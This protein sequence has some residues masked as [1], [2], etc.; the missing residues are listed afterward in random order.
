MEVGSRPIRVQSIAQNGVA[1]QVP[2]EYIQPPETR[3]NYPTARPANNNPIPSIDLSGAAR[4]ADSLRAEIGAACRDWGAFHV[5]NH[6]VPPKLLDE[7]RRVGR[8]FFEACPMDEKLRYSC[9]T[10]GAA[11][12][13]YGSRML[14]ASNDTVLDWRDYFDHHTLPVS[15]R[16]PS[17]WPQFPPDYRQRENLE[18][19]IQESAPVSTQALVP[20]ASLASP[21]LQLTN[22]EVVVE[23]SDHMKGLAQKLLGLIS[24]SLGL[25]SSCIE[26][27][28][29][30]FYQNISIN[31]YPPCPQP[32]LTLG[33]QAHS[34]MGAITLLIQDDV[35][36]LQIF[37]DDEW[38]TV[39]PLSDAIRK[40]VT[41]IQLTPINPSNPSLANH[42]SSD[43][44]D[45]ELAPGYPVGKKDKRHM[46]SKTAAG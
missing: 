34:D 18:I 16:D 14:V 22:R 10:S 33:L 17:R 37:K 43:P 11:T 31:Y 2:P 15:R 28:V 5:T 29:G 44:P 1:P 3:P 26:E 20:L 27:A 41:S 39:D 23:Y 8:T 32:D 19:K 40:T 12:E 24:E 13:G 30:E 7:I 6:G 21:F 46:L 25:P 4:D 35:G 36:G 45:V 42:S 9:D 38:I